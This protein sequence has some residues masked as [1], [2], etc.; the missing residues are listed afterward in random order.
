MKLSR[1]SMNNMEPFV[2]L[3]IGLGKNNLNHLFDTINLGLNHRVDRIVISYDDP[4]LSYNDSATIIKNAIE[5]SLF[6]R[7]W[8]QVE[9]VPYCMFS[10][11]EHHL[12]SLKHPTRINYS[13]ILAC[14]TC[15][16]KFCCPGIWDKYLKNNN[17]KQFQSVTKSP[18]FK[19][20][21]ELFN[22]KS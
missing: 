20:L 19:D 9:K 21:K 12:I 15:A 5:M 4:Q 13:K 18:Y 3:K 14:K 2:A 16:Y 22:A 6:S 17:P 1:I 8:V 10:G 7:I 11:Y